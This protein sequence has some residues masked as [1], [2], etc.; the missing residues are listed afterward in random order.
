MATDIYTTDK[1]Y[2]IIYADPPWKYKTWRDGMGTAEKTLPHNEYR[3]YS[4]YEGYNQKNFQIVIVFFFC[5]LHSP[6]Y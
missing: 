1:K 3:G 2:K 4:K 5:G 6:A